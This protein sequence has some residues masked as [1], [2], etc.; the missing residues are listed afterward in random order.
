LEKNIKDRKE[1]DTQSPLL[2]DDTLGTST[3]DEHNSSVLQASSEQ[4]TTK[5]RGERRKRQSDEQMN[6]K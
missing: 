2:N 6:T 3:H 1:I 4:G 5:D